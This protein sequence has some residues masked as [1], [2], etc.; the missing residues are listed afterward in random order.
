MRTLELRAGRPAL[1]HERP[2]GIDCRGDG[3]GRAGE[4]GDDAVALALLDWPHAAVVGDD[5]VE[6]LVVPGDRDGH[7]LP[8]CAP[9][10]AM[11]PR[12]RSAGR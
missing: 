9:T 10:V 4:R 12:R 7:R 3:V 11:T 1:G 2:L 8:A 5:L 6:D